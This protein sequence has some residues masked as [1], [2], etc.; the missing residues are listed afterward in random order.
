LSSPPKDPLANHRATTRGAELLAEGD[1]LS[2]DRHPARAM[3]Q[4]G[5]EEVS[6]REIISRSTPHRAGSP[7]APPYWWKFVG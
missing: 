2:S 1:G 3:H 6:R 7:E 4:A 5:V